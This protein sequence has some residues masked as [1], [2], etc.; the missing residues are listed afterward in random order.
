[1]AQ[2]PLRAETGHQDVSPK[3]L[4]DFSTTSL[5]RYAT[6]AS[7]REG[8][9]TKDFLATLWCESHWKWNARGDYATS[10]GYT[11]FGIAQLHYPSRDWGISTSTALNPYVSIDIAAAAFSNGEM[12]RWTC[13]RHYS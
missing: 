13:Y 12:H 11:S 8:I 1:M 5:V 3:V 6:E 2:A 9:N 7:E 10:T 4:S